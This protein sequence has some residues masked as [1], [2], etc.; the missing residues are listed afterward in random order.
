MKE[1]YAQRASEGQTQNES[2]KKRR[3]QGNLSPTPYDLG[4]RKFIK[5]N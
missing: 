4:I 5:K 1:D 3:A 2:N